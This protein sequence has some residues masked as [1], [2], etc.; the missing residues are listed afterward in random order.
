MLSA[1]D[2]EASKSYESAEHCNDAGRLGNRVH[3]H[4]GLIHDTRLPA[5]SET[6]DSDVANVA[7]EC[8]PSVRIVTADIDI[9]A[10]L[11]NRRSIAPIRMSLIGGEN[12]PPL[13]K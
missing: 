11:R 8:G 3:T 7:V 9:L 6:P 12:V 4:S 2:A 1:A 5:E 13:A 10:E